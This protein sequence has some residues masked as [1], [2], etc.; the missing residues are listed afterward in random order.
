MGDTPQFLR[1]DFPN[2]ANVN[3]YFEAFEL[4]NKHVDECEI[5][6]PAED[7]RAATPGGER[8]NLPGVDDPAVGVVPGL[9]RGP[10]R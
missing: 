6:L 10:R 3:M 8:G 7:P 5:D 4:Q 2:N 1:I 9:A